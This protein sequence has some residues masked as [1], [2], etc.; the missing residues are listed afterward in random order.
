MYDSLINKMTEHFSEVGSI[1]FG[2]ACDFSKLH[3]I[4]IEDIE[5]YYDI[6]C[7]DEPIPPNIVRRNHKMCCL[8]YLSKERHSYLRN[9]TFA[10]L[11]SVLRLI[12]GDIYQ[13]RL[14]ALQDSATL[15]LPLDRYGYI[16][17]IDRAAFFMQG[18]IGIILFDPLR[19]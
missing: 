14:C 5:M 2:K 10:E 13:I 18:N 3:D 4:S 11:L 6:L 16:G 1:L 19:S 8:F 17:L 15:T 12:I 9:R 7:S